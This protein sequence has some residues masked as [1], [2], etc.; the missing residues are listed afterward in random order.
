M[1]L[2]KYLQRAHLIKRRTV[3]KDACERERVLVNGRPAKPAYEVRI[4]DRLEIRLGGRVMTVEVLEMKETM[5]PEE[6]RRSYR[7]LSVERLPPED[8]TDG[9]AAE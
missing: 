4:G 5:R 2:D 9:E 3:A 7:L 8:G 6:A 1:R